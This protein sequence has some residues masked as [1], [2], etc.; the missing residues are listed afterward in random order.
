VLA[1][2]LYVAPMLV[3]EGLTGRACHASLAIGDSTSLT[4][5]RSR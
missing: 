5:T 1:T 4:R 3:R 2:A